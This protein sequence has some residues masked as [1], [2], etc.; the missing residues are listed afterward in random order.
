MQKC[1]AFFTSKSVTLYSNTISSNIAFIRNKYPIYYIKA[2]HERQTR[3]LRTLNKHCTRGVAVIDPNHG[4][5]SI[6][7]IVQVPEEEQ[8]AF[9]KAFWQTEPFK[10]MYQFFR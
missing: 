8:E 5:D 3:R 1:T 4:I 2:H 7:V 9:T 6:C 10:S